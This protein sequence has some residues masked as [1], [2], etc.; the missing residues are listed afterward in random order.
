MVLN[1]SFTHLTP[2]DGCEVQQP[3]RSDIPSQQDEDK[4][5]KTS[6][7]IRIVANVR[8]DFEL[9]PTVVDLHAWDLISSMYFIKAQAAKTLTR[10]VGGY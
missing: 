10:W 4:S 5:P 1:N 7:V 3:K 2:K 9:P 8:G 6:C